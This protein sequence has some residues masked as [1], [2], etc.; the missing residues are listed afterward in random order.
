[1]SASDAAA[2]PAAAPADA[3]LSDAPP[4]PVL[5]D[6]AGA[7]ALQFLVDQQR[8]QIAVLTSI[9]RQLQ[10][11]IVSA[12]VP[13]AAASVAPLPPA[14]APVL[15]PKNTGPPELPPRTLRSIGAARGGA[16]RRRPGTAAASSAFSS[17]VPQLP[18]QAAVGGGE[19]DRAP[20]HPPR[21]GRRPLVPPQVADEEVDD[22]VPAPYRLRRETRNG[23][24]RR[25][26]DHRSN[27]P[28]SSKD[29]G[30]FAARDEIRAGSS[31]VVRA[32]S[33]MV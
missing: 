25:V 17:T 4:A 22:D 23:G 8:E 14:A 15:V 10:T 26:W 6:A 9:V 31:Y 11:Q 7:S 21:G 29:A 28:R 24:A 18:N 27:T 30:R 19:D 33:G 16:A 32:F 2:A 5:A 12:P 1:M 3:P 13:A 20:L